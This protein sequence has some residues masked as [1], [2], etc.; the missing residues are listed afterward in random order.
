MISVFIVEDDLSLQRL[1]EMMLTTFGFEVVDK[2][3]NGKEAIDKFKSLS[4]K[5]DVILMDHRMPVKNGID[6]TIEL[7][8]FN[9]PTK[10]IFTSA[11][12]SVKGRALE[13]GAVSFI[14]KPFTVIQLQ[15]EM[16]RVVNLV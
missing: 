8:K 5:P 1:Y 15:T 16:N 6:T 10:I 11:D 7:L 2:A 13:V 12:N 14:E 4:P 3:S 9:S